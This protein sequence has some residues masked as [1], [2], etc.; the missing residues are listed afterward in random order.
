MI[1]ITLLVYPIFLSYLSSAR[2]DNTIFHQTMYIPSKM[3][4]FIEINGSKI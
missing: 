2:H 1:M 3:W 4:L